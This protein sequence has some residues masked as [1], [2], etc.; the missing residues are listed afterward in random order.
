MTIER[1][2]FP[3]GE[4][5]SPKTYSEDIGRL[6]HKHNSEFI[7]LEPGTH[8]DLTPKEKLRNNGKF[9][10]EVLANGTGSLALYYSG[11]HREKGEKKKIEFVDSTLITQNNPIAV[12]DGTL[13]D[14]PRPRIFEIIRY[15]KEEIGNR[16]EE[17][18]D[19]KKVPVAA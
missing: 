9:D 12:V 11:K 18:V 5:T 8:H 3:E 6:V 16:E 17:S 1:L 10:L 2:S 7:P 15:I 13:V 14:D 4:V 19:P